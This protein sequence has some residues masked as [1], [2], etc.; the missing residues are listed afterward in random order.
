MAGGHAQPGA[1]VMALP[2]SK[3][4]VATPAW[5]LTSAGDCGTYFTAA[6]A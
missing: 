2:L 5:A 6:A 3:A 4:A 1:R